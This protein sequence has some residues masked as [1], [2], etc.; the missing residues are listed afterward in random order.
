VRR[1]LAR[2]YSAK[3][4]N[5]SFLSEKKFRLQNKM[6]ELRDRSKRVIGEVKGDIITKWEEKSRDFIEAFLMLFGRESSLRQLWNE[7]KGRIM[8]AVSQP[9]SPNGS[10]NGDEQ[11]DNHETDGHDSILNSPPTKRS[12]KFHQLSSQLNEYNY[13]KTKQQQQPQ[14]TNE[15][16]EEEEEED[17]YNNVGIDYKKSTSVNKKH[18]GAT[19]ASST[20]N[21]K[22]NGSRR[23]VNDDDDD[24]DYDDSH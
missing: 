9:G 23:T 18:N 11:N 17:D 10:E 20:N 4:L 19:S 7:S 5:V 24:D 14:K 12:F 3:E 1:N 13:S 16:D 6:D 21:N 8:Q 15:S 22:S 2:G